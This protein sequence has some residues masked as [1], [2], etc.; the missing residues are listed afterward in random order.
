MTR[1]SF[2]L[3]MAVVLLAGP[4]F[5]WG[6]EVLLIVE[7][8]PADGLVMAH[9]DLTPAVQR[10][11]P[12]ERI[13]ATG[14]R[15]ATGPAGRNVP[16]QLVPD[17]DY[18]AL[19]HVAG[20]LVLRLP[21]D[22]DGRVRLRFTAGAARM[23][24]WN[25]RVQMPGARTGEG[26]VASSD[27]GRI[28][29]PS[30]HQADLPDGLPIRPTGKPTLLVSPGASLVHDAKRQGGF[31]SQISFADG[32]V[33][34]SLRW[35][36]R[37]YDPQLGAFSPVADPQANVT[38]VSQGPLCTAVRVIGCYVQA[39]GK[40]PSSAPQAVYDWLYLA[41]RPLVLVRAAMR[42][43]EPFAWPELHFLELDYPQES[44]PRWVG[45]EPLEQ[46][47]F[48]ASKKSLGALQLSRMRLTIS[49]KTGLRHSI[50]P[51][52]SII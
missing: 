34:D 45:G 22:S 3:W 36:D 23:E 7:K 50:L 9:V 25:G 15:A 10:C 13:E 37:L 26:T 46:G 21:A 40:A 18:D 47:L 27:V 39:S 31:P 43:K 19:K 41:D 8:P 4:A 52:S 5:A 6:D 11:R 2:L 1:L 32:K 24:R 29:N 20:T 33:F 28:A 44:F 35:N 14:I 49:A 12:M 48:T 42:Q 16:I 17:A 38:L 30:S 51:I